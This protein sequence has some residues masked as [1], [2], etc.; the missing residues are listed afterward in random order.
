MSALGSGARCGQHSSGDSPHAPA[1][2]VAAQPCG[3]AFPLLALPQPCLLVVFEALKHSLVDAVALSSCCRE[4]WGLGVSARRRDVC[5][6]ACGHKVLH[7]DQAFA[8]DAHRDCHRL[9]LPD[10]D[11]YAV[12]A[13]HLQ[14]GCTLG[15]AQVLFSLRAVLGIR[16]AGD[17]GFEVT[18]REVLCGGCG[19]HLG[20]R[21]CQLGKLQASSTAGG[22]ISQWR[23]LQVL[24]TCF[25]AKRFLRLRRPD[26]T[27]EHLGRPPP[28]A[29]LACYR[30][31]GARSSLLP[32]G[33]CGADLFESRDIL[34]RQHCWDAGGGPERAF[35]INAFRPGAVEA[36]NERQETLSQG[37]M[38]VAD[39]HCATCGACIGW[40]F[41]SDLSPA[42]ENCNQVGRY[43]VVRSSIRKD[44][45]R[46]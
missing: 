28:A 6:A 25:L 8:S 32:A 43:G 44:K 10:G 12:E 34:S 5:C 39:V 36:R 33:G 22:C 4:L 14:G 2:P 37:E 35:F 9:E 29:E 13:T 7:P 23:K 21:I 31:T 16:G 3:P 1:T 11:S 27:E 19:L 38:R 41:V 24:G 40:K 30:C 45:A 17:P 20:L 15:K 46:L 42:L 26:G 18:A